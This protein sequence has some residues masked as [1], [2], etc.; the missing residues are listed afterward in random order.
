MAI[1]FSRENLPS[2]DQLQLMYGKLQSKIS[3]IDAM[4]DALNNSN[5]TVTEIFNNLKGSYEAAESTVTENT[6]ALMESQIQCLRNSNTNPDCEDYDRRRS[7]TIAALAKQADEFSTYQ[8]SSYFKSPQ[9]FLDHL[10]REKASLQAQ[11]EKVQSQ[12]DLS[13][14]YLG[15][16]LDDSKLAV[17]NLSLATRDRQWLQFE[18]DSSSF[19]K[20]ES[21]ESTSKRVS[22]SF[23][24][25]F[26][27]FRASASYSSTKNTED[28][29]QKLAKSNLRAKG[30]MLRVNI[31]RPWFKPE[32]FEIPDIT[33][34]SC[35]YCTIES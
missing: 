3:A 18:Y 5:D 17:A 29:N 28:Y 22:A 1:I 25:G 20:D 27:F 9:K 33:F 11:I 23:S 6:T 26:W 10:I 32:L 7:D 24:G 34:V 13:S 31:K 16:F 15:G 35:I 12:L 30:E 19:S 4:A 21:R 14:P 2:A 8:Y